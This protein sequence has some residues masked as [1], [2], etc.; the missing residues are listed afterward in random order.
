MVC[1]SCQLVEFHWSVGLSDIPSVVMH[2]GCTW[3]HEPE[4]SSVVWEVL[5][6]FG[7]LINL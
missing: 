7:I 4:L 6:F 5:V 3:S 1:V 2:F